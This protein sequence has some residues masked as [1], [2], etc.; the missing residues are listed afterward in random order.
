MPGKPIS[1]FP[2][3]PIPYYWNR[4]FL[5]L[6]A[7]HW[8]AAKELLYNGSFADSLKNGRRE[9]WEKF[10]RIIPAVQPDQDVGLFAFAM[11]VA[12][13]S[14][15]WVSPGGMLAVAKAA[16][17]SMSPASANEARIRQLLQ[18]APRLVRIYHEEDHSSGFF[19]EEV[20]EA[21]R[22][23]AGLINIEM[24]PAVQPG[25]PKKVSFQ[26]QGDP[27]VDA[28]QLLNLD[29]D[30]ALDE[31]R[32][33]SDRDLQYGLEIVRAMSALKN[34]AAH[35]FLERIEKNNSLSKAVR[36]QA[37]KYLVE[38]PG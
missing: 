34:A 10:A 36:R 30:R 17:Q 11:A 1:F 9:D 14:D 31:L 33:Q 29:P 19:Y 8:Q 6:I 3:G 22:F 7:E 5:G 23:L 35:Q 16:A 38:N 12:S 26:F 20:N 13:A 27:A 2:D 37:R 25:P 21:Y 15:K 28:G 24:F 4:E 18:A 32:Y